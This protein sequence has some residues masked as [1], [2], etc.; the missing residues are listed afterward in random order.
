MIY[1]VKLTR[2]PSTPTYELITMMDDGY[3][4]ESIYK[5]L[6]D[7]RFPMEDVKKEIMVLRLIYRL[8]GGHMQ[9]KRVK[10]RIIFYRIT[11]PERDGKF[12][13]SQFE[14]YA[15]RYGYKQLISFTP[16][17]CL[18]KY[19]YFTMRAIWF[20]RYLNKVINE[21]YLSESDDYVAKDVYISTVCKACGPY[22]KAFAQALSIYRYTGDTAT[23]VD[24]KLFASIGYLCDKKTPNA[25]VYWRILK[26][27]KEH[28]E[29]DLRYYSIE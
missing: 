24:E 14:Q 9:Y 12:Y 8:L 17:D 20:K 22:G 18:R 3:S 13:T 19:S 16:P 23:A 28:F 1:K 4:A 5:R 25:T 6:T 15:E 29:R 7:G 2:D 10:Y 11:M 26:R 21:V 27:M